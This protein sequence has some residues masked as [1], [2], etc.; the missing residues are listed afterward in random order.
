MWT[1]PHFWALSLWRSR[2]LCPRRRADAAGGARAS[3]SP[4]ARSWLYTLVLVPLG[5][6]PAFIGLGGPL[7]LAASAGDRASGSLLGSLRHLCAR[8]DEVQGARGATGCSA[9]RCSI[10]FVPVRGPDR[11]AAAPA[12]AA[13]RHEAMDD[14]RRQN[15]ARRERRKRNIALA[16]VL[17]GVGDLV[18]SDVDRA[19][20][21]AF[22]PLERARS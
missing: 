4:A 22:E 3:R 15:A 17:G 9:F 14:E 21:R 20:A 2:R 19:V 8:S 13:S 10:L 1:P 18:L 6:A 16:L 5:V 7:Y 11:G 12:S